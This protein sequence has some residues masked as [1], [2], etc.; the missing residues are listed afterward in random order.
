MRTIVIY[1]N[2][3]GVGKTTS[4]VNIA[5]ALHERKLRTLVVDMDPQANSTSTFNVSTDGVCTITDVIAKGSK[6]KISDAIVSTDMGDIVPGDYDLNSLESDIGG[7]RL[8]I[9]KQKLEEVQDNYD[10]CIIDTP[11][12]IGNFTLSS[13]LAA[14]EYILPINGGSTYAIDGIKNAFKSIEDI[15]EVNADLQYDGLLMTCYDS[16]KKKSDVK[17]WN[18]IV[19]S[20]EQLK[21]FSRPIRVDSKVG[22]SQENKYSLQKRAYNSPA[23]IDFRT[24]ADEIINMYQ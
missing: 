4:C 16:R 24:I 17:Y 9:L 3:G 12:N 13:L 11:P 14:D 5:D 6:Y 22:D 19:E 20:A 7:A 21:P 18:D 2:K 8:T 1:N 23:A 15:L 10:F